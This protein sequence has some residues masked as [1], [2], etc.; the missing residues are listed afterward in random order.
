MLRFHDVAI[1]LYIATV[2]FSAVVIAETLHREAVF[3]H[4]FMEK[5]R[6]YV[7]EFS[8]KSAAYAL[9]ILD[10]GKCYHLPHEGK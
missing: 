1:V 7:V 6:Q 2:D 4:I 8:G 3:Q 9:G 5:C 10:T